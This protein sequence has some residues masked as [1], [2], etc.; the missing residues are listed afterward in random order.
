MSFNT[1]NKP[2]AWELY[3]IDSDPSE[4]HDIAAEHQDVVHRLATTYEKW[5][6]SVQPDLV[7]EDVDGPPE[8]PFKTATGS[9]LGHGQHMKT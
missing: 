2:D 4:E 5:W 7:N 3:D 6:E 1:K 8:N 9:S